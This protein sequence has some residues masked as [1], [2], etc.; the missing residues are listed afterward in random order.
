MASILGTAIGQPDLKWLLISDAELQSR[1]ESFGMSKTIVAW[2]VEMQANMHNGPF[3]EDYYRNRPALG[4]VKL[5]EFAKE[6]TAV[7]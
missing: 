6:F 4:N 7:F 1:Y 5:S 2:L 3:Y